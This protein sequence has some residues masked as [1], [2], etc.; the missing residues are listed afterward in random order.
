MLTHLDART[1]VE[2]MGT[3]QSILSEYTDQDGNK[4]KLYEIVK[5][6][7]NVDTKKP[8]GIGHAV[9]LF[10]SWM[11]EDGTYVT[12]YLVDID[13]LKEDLLK[14]CDLE[15]IESDT[16]KNQMNMHESFFKDGYCEYEPNIETREYLSKVSKYYESNEINKNCYTFTNLHRYSI[17]RKKDVGQTGGYDIHNI[18]KYSV[19][20]MGM[21]DLDYSL[22][23]SIHQIFKTHK[24]I[25]ET[26][27]T[28]DLFADMNLKLLK[29]YELDDN[30]MVKLLS[31]IKIEHELENDKV[32][33]IVDG[34]N[35]C[36]FERDGHNNYKV[37]MIKTKKRNPKVI[38]MI[39]EGQLYKPLYISINKEKQAMFK[40]NDE[41]LNQILKE[42]E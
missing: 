8:I 3:S 10:A 36:T 13:F 9:D 29:D 40:H 11:F 20:N 1:L 38:T 17:F 22:Q 34:V 24:V 14:S 33:K 31:K 32:K 16:F 25:P 35:I 27:I 6:Y 41:L 5:K 28:E 18:E 37:N 7:D 12:E 15:L 42:Y 2:R 23:N 4:E 26:L 39:K 19:P 21:Y 30:V